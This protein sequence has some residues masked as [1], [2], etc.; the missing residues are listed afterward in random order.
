M[1]IKMREN[2][3]TKSFKVLS[4]GNSFSSDGMEYLYQISENLGAE[5][6][7]L[8]N[9]YIAGCSLEK[10][11]H[12]AENYI[13]GYIYYKNNNGIWKETPDFKSLDAIREEK[14]DFIT[15]Q[16]GSGPS[17]K[18]ETYEPYLSNLIE[19]VKNNTTN[20]EL[21]LVWLNTWAYQ[22]D[23][24]H[25]AFPDYNN[26]QMTMYDT[27]LNA[28]RSEVMTKEDISIIIPAGIAIQYARKDFGD[29]LTRDGYHLSIPLGR[30]IAALTWAAA[31]TGLDYTKITYIPEDFVGKNLPL[32]IK[33]VRKAFEI[34]L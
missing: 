27:I 32:V 17:G 19:Y 14:W 26:D 30:Y 13:S 18:P 9:L 4:V 5:N 31:L 22:A 16:Q 11:W 3:M 28:L 21:K 24:T 15:L 1:K 20:P 25:T 29:V 12:C 7:I 8:G 2:I 34:K 23:G 6:I 10:H 33:A